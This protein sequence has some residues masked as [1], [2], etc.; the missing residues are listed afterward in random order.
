MKKIFL[1]LFLFSIGFSTAAYAETGKNLNWC[2]SGKMKYPFYIHGEKGKIKKHKSSDALEDAKN[3]IV[4]I[5]NY[6]GGNAQKYHGICK[7]AAKNF[8]GLAGHKI[9]NLETIWW[10]NDE[11]K[12]AGGTG[13]KAFYKCKEDGPWGA[14]GN[15]KDQPSDT[16]K[17]FWPCIMKAVPEWN[18]EKRFQMMEGIIKNFINAGVPPNQIFVSGVSA[19]GV[20]AAR[21][22]VQYGGKLINAGIAF[23][24]ANWGSHPAGARRTLFV[25]EM[26][27]VERIE[28]LVVNS[29]SD[30]TGARK[31]RPEDSQWLKDIPGV[32]YLETAHDGFD[33]KN[34]TKYDGNFEIK[35]PDGV[36]CNHK[37]KWNKNSINYEDR[38]LLSLGEAGDIMKRREAHDMVNQKCMQYYWPQVLN[39]ITKRIEATQ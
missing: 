27:S 3:K 21:S 12:K 29:N 25:E 13:N 8:A 34:T 14:D 9:G 11:I 5:Y 17:W 36:K 16:G 32:E 6:G 38:Y 31:M 33:M 1:A 35:T 23:H 26:K 28:M 15:K 4:I 24:P 20:D 19:G 2:S 39:Y 7:K 30:G 37:G 22:A 10:Y 18:A